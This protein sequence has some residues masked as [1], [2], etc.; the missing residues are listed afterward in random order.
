MDYKRWT[1]EEK[2]AHILEAL[3]RDDLPIELTELI[4]GSLLSEENNGKQ[5]AVMDAI[6]DRMFQQ[7]TH[8]TLRAF[9]SLARVH[10]KIGFTEEKRVKPGWRLTAR[11]TLLRVAAVLLPFA[12]VGGA[13]W[14]ALKPTSLPDEMVEVFGGKSGVLTLPDGSI[15][16]PTKGSHVMVSSN[17]TKNRHVL[18]SGEAFF[19]V[20]RDEK[21]PFSV[22][23]EDLTVT[24]LGTEFNLQADP[25]GNET[26]VSLVTGSV[27]VESETQTVVLAP[28]E[29]LVYDATTGESEVSQF[30]SERIER[31]RS[32]RKE[33]N[34]VSL[35][36]ALASVGNF[37][38]MT[39]EVSGHLPDGLNVTTV[40]SES[41]TVESVLE[42]IRLV[43]KAF[44][45]KIGDNTI[46]IAGKK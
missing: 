23:T 10:E 36:Q 11:R 1:E 6:L 4:H 25:K 9:E 38:D 19:S 20:A 13:M 2:I 40:L 8:L 45:Y 28:M 39:L 37:Y 7:H 16:R 35:G 43:N 31:W 17:F 3:S 27:E 21:E 26:V 29:Q 33:L 44:E 46:Y 18:L 41:V 22:E 24:V 5:E 34:G 15:V 30:P 14:I 42:A 32:G 12:V